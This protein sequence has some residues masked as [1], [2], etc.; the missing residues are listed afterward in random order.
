MVARSRSSQDSR[1]CGEHVSIGCVLV[2]SSAEY[3]RKVPAGRSSHYTDKERNIMRGHEG[4][5]ILIQIYGA[6]KKKPITPIL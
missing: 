3:L 6:P 4:V 5:E 2:L 1:A